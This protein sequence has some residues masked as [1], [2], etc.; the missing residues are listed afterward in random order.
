LHTLAD[1]RAALKSS[2]GSWTEDAVEAAQHD[3]DA[4]VKAEWAAV[5]GAQ[6]RLDEAQRG[7]LKARAARLLLDA[8]LV[9]L[10]LGQQPEMFGE[11]TYPVAF[12][13][14]AV[15]GLKRHG[16]PWAPLLTYA[17]SHIQTPRPTDPFFVEIQGYPAGRLK[18][19]FGTLKR[20]ARELVQ[21]IAVQLQ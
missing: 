6:A 2:R 14:R 10:A 20:Q 15:I 12:D 13:K 18:R 5:E 3:L 8:A 17:Y 1:L 9:E 11:E 19:R 7:A 16:Y 4:R 21:Q